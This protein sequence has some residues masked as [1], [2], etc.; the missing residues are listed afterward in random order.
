MF[1]ELRLYGVL[2]RSDVGSRT[3]PVLEAQGVR[4]VELEPQDPKHTAC[5]LSAEVRELAALNGDAHHW[6]EGPE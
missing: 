5:D 6:L 3:S 4:G 1:R 2:G